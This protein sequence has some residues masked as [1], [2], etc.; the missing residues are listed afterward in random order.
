LK[1]EGE[2]EILI[3]LDDVSML[4]QRAQQ[5]KLASLG[6]LTASIAH[7]V[8]NPLGAISH[9]GQLLSESTS[10]S[11]DDIR[12]TKIIL[13]HSQ[14]VNNIIENIMSISRR[15]QTEP[16][17]IDL[18][19]WLENFIKEFEAGQKLDTGA[20]SLHN[21]VDKINAWM[22]PGQLHQVLWNIIEN[23]IRYSRGIPLIELK[24]SI[25]EE[26]QRP[27]IDVID[28]GPGIQAEIE[29]QL[30]EPFFTTNSKGAGLGLYIARELCEANQA[31]LSLHRNTSDGC[32]FRINFTHP[33]KQ[34]N[35]M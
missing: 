19:S 23:G 25:R 17:G 15:K 33:D 35:L 4:R 6:R 5:L 18:R 32:C 16:V 1:L 28:H 27:F 10:I 13:D 14:R 7:E 9:A 22:D 12:F 11:P 30:F 20:I 2:F 21:T 29:E 24:Y 31:T 26:T 3:F 8:R 34:H